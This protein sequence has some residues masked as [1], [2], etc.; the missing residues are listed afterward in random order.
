M[1]FSYPLDAPVVA[2]GALL[3]KY[4]I[5]RSRKEKDEFRFQRKPYRNVRKI[6]LP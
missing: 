5:A 1:V 6:G 4:A 3:M 2:D